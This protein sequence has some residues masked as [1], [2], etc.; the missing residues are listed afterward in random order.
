M[1]FG[2]DV[3]TALCKANKKIRHSELRIWVQVDFRFLDNESA[4]FRSPQAFHENGE[5]LAYSKA[6]VGKIS[7]SPRVCVPQADLENAR[8]FGNSSEWKNRTRPTALSHRLTDL[9]NSPRFC[10]R[11]KES[12]I[13]ARQQ[14]D[15]RRLSFPKRVPGIRNGD[16]AAAERPRPLVLT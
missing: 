4:T 16:L 6:H 15:R 2:D 7:P 5:R 3:P 1:C 14:I 13:N 12:S 8:R 11:R 10:P 9:N